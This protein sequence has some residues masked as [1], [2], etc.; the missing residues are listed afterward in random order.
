MKMLIAQEMAKEGDANQ[1]T[2]NVVARLMGL[3]DNVDLPKH[4]VPSNRRSFPDGHL[5]ATLARVNNQIS[6]EK[7]TSSAEDVEYKD[8]YEVG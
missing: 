1:K 5:S 2:T 6:F 7:H 4:V 8:V 3:D